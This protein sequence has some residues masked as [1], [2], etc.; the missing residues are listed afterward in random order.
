MS[1]NRLASVSKPHSNYNGAARE[2][3]SA[4]K[5]IFHLGGWWTSVSSDRERDKENIMSVTEAFFKVEQHDWQSVLIQYNIFIRRP[6]L[7]RS[8]GEKPLTRCREKDGNCKVLLSG[9]VA[10]RGSIQTDS[11]LK[12]TKHHSPALLALQSKQ[13]IRRQKFNAGNT[14]QNTH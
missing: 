13:I 1:F 14:H 8:G 12:A 7:S 9:S 3:E 10:L 6:V 2:R 5:Y 4:V 11:I